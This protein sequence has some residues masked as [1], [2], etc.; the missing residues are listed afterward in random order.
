MSRHAS[1]RLARKFTVKIVE[2]IPGSKPPLAGAEGHLNVLDAV[3]AAQRLQM[4]VPL[5]PGSDLVDAK[6]LGWRI[7]SHH[8]TKHNQGKP[9][10]MP[11]R[12]K[13]EVRTKTDQ[14]TKAAGRQPKSNWQFP[15]NHSTLFESKRE[16]DQKNRDCRNITGRGSDS[17]SPHLIHLGLVH[18]EL[19][20]ITT[21]K[22]GE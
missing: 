11:V 12:R 20:N 7:C 1:W 10:G 4:F 21:R 6:Q 15:I 14:Q 13:I 22:R 18:G 8:R 2:D 16:R 5:G 17:C 9:A 19:R 3:D